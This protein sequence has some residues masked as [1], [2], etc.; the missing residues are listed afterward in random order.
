[1]RYEEIGRNSRS[2]FRLGQRYL[3]RHPLQTAL[4]VL[5]IALGVA[6]AVAIDLANVSAERAF[7]LSAEAVAGRATHQITGGPSGLEESLYASLV[8]SA[9]APP[10][11]PV[12]HEYVASPQLGDR[13]LQLLGIDPFAEEPFRN[14][15]GGEPGIR[16]DA[17]SAPRGGPGAARL[18]DFL[19]RPGAVL[20]SAESARRYG[21]EPCSP[22]AAQNERCRLALEIG[23]EVRQAWI[24]GL[25]EAGASGRTAGRLSER[26]LEGL[27][28]ADVATAQELT[29]RLGRLDRIDLI[30][31]EACA[32]ISIP[33]GAGEAACPE[34]QQLQALLPAGASL[35]P[36]EAR[37]ASIQQMAAAFRL[38]L[39]A[40][41]LLALVVGTFLIYNTM[42]FSVVSRRELFGTLRCL[43]VT[44]GEVFAL[45][46]AEALIAGA[47]GA[48]LGI[49]LGVAMGKAT[50]ARVAQTI[51]DLYFV[52]TVT[53]VQVPASSLVKGALLGV[54]ATLLSAAPPAWE[55]ASAP[56]RAA[57]SRAG[58]ERKAGQ[59]VSRAAILGAVLLAAGALLLLAGASPLEASFAG[60]LAV[61]AGFALLAP[62][63]TRALVRLLSPLLGK[64]F[65]AVGRMAPRNVGAALSRTAVA[66]AALMVAVSVS[67]GVG[68][69]VGSFRH[70]VV[71]WLDQTLQGDV[72]LS[73]PTQ[74]ATEP[75]APLDPVVAARVKAW[76][77]AARVDSLRSVSVDSPSGAVHLAAVDN[78]TLAYERLF[79]AAIGAPGEVQQALEQG[80][81]LISEPFANRAGLPRRGGRITLHTAD[82][83]RDF[84]VAGVYYDYASSQGTVL[85][86]L[87]TYRR[88]WQDDALSA[89]ALRLAPGQDA[90][91]VA[92]ELQEALAPLQRLQVR[93][94]R[95]L[96]QDVMEVFDRTFAITGALQLLATAVAFIGVLSAL[97][98][99]QLERQRELGIL[100]AVGL[101]SRQLWGLLMAESG[102]M[103]GIAGLLAMPTGFSLALILV[104]IINR[105]SFGW[106]LQMQVGP[107][108]F[109]QAFAVA[110]VAALLAGIYPA[111]RMAQL[112]PA[113]ALRSE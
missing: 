111:R 92:D 69:M 62:L 102:L 95:V 80:Y 2:L 21:L 9:G 16:E 81:V 3:W 1:M 37:R 42:T 59:A 104:Y 100:R 78:P 63:A 88:W 103:G 6:V 29:G 48:V 56:P 39:T 13:P 101:T 47:L 50:V 89:M 109:L 97:L 61:I 41:S 49:V 99:L 55:A 98:S 70:T 46:C 36:V 25:L 32:A 51:N 33:P 23:G 110:L 87:Q 64:A 79:L 107:G 5:G 77:G 38:N 108:P 31:P 94:N 12:I 66:L 83:P 27:I 96:R 52:V 76:P 40:L 22:A 19:T 73:A 106:T 14:Y 105:R 18:A 113:E 7:E 82:G 43:G 68:L 4:M 67:L 54:I 8:S 34:A 60:T 11:A 93:P 28:L 17:G 84:P 91:Q 58:L 85:M 24:A 45:V 57:L 53:R 71:A 35:Q 90:G 75:S 72:Y 10:A 65:G 20:I 74:T 15:L 112:P 30:L 86:S 44:R 26:A